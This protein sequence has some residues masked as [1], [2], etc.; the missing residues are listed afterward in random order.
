[1]GR[2]K[3]LL[4]ALII[5]EAFLAAAPLINV[6]VWG[7]YYLAYGVN[8]WENSTMYMFMEGTASCMSWRG[9]A[10]NLLSPSDSLLIT[11]MEQEVSME[12]RVI[13]YVNRS[14]VLD[15]ALNPNPITSPGIH[16]TA[17]SIIES[18][19]P[20]NYLVLVELSFPK[21]LGDGSYTVESK[22]LSAIAYVMYGG[23]MHKVVLDSP[24]SP[25]SNPEYT[26][27]DA[28][29][30]YDVKLMPTWLVTLKVVSA[31]LYPL[32][33]IPTATLT[34]VA[35][36]GRRGLRVALT[37]ALIA[38][39]A[40]YVAGILTGNVAVLLN[41]LLKTPTDCVKLVNGTATT[42]M[43]IRKSI[44]AG[45]GTNE[46]I[47]LSNLIKPYEL[48]ALEMLAN[49]TSKEHPTN[50][51]LITVEPGFTAQ[52]ELITPTQKW[53]A[54]PH[55][56]NPNELSKAKLI[57]KNLTNT[58]TFIDIYIGIPKTTNQY[59]KS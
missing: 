3:A 15:V 30:S 58:T 10:K 57:I 35:T 5:A 42:V 44:M 46:E 56:V 31:A 21:P 18:L 29:I 50:K 27:S 25:V 37:I 52:T 54:G 20:S 7:K 41:Y 24:F 51:L 9:L 16:G 19:P 49:Y 23:S 4:A 45:P 39:A 28:V 12:L 33:L 43:G 34:Y 13:N 8:L 40:T 32:M 55:Y 6:Y 11:Y 36:R 48:K 59:L 38:T 1:M 47:N 17:D 22:P 26:V 53:E 14:T 2:L